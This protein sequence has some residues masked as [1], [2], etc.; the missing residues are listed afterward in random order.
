MKGSLCEI[1]SFHLP[2]PLLQCALT[3]SWPLKNVCNDQVS[4]VSPSV[5]TFTTA[6]GDLYHGVA[7]TITSNKTELKE[8]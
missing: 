7:T 4:E 3:M 6:L 5:F 1:N 2:C 8:G